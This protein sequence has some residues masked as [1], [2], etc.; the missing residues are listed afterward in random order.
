ML[1][2]EQK[3]FG[4]LVQ[5]FSLATTWMRVF[6]REYEPCTQRLSNHTTAER[7]FALLASISLAGPP[8]RI[9]CLAPMEY[10]RKVFFPPR[11]QRRI[12]SS[13]IKPGISNLSITSPTLY[14]LNYAVAR[15]I[16]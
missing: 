12:A 9:G 16:E 6:V 4:V 13:G 7:F 11:T 15:L 3:N 10:K 2:L 14:Q 1:V 5:A 8:L